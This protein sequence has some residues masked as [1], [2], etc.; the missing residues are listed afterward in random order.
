[1]QVTDLAVSYPGRPRVVDG[2][3]L[4][5][6]TGEIVGVSG[7]SGCGK[8][9]LALALIGLLPAH[10]NVSGS[11]RFAGRELREMHERDLESIRGAGIGLVFQESALALSPLLTVGT[12]ITE[13]V[14]AHE[15]C[16]HCA[17]TERARAV[18]SD[19]GLDVERSR[20]FN[21]YPHELSGGQRQRILIAQATACCPRLIVADEPVASLDE[22]T[23]GDVLALIR[24]L[25][26]RSGTS[27]LLITHS[28]E[29]LQT[30][31]TRVVEMND[32]RFMEASRPLRGA[33]VSLSTPRIVKAARPTATAE[34]IVEVSGLSKTYERRLLFGRRGPRVRALNGVDVTI[35]RGSTLG[36]AGR[37]GCG[38]STFARCLAGLEPPDAGQIR[39]NGT[40][41]AALEGRSLLPFRNQVQVIFQDSAAALNP[42]FSAFDIVAEP[43]VIQ[44]I[45][46]TADQRKRAA[47]LMEQVGLAADRLES[48]P[49]EFSGGERQR[50]AIARALAVNPRVL[51]L[52]ESFSGLDPTTRE[53][54]L[55]L[56]TEIQAAHGLTYVCIS[57]DRQLLAG[58]ATDV[59]V[60]HE[61]RIES[62]H[63]VIELEG[64]V[65]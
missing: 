6:E 20:I 35:A 25:N 42:R 14:R 39:I 33:A 11:I 48:R 43:L 36:V 40:N 18:M 38:K 22:G 58:F 15:R 3:S 44:G 52:D 54:I 46:T 57:H 16:S 55:R 26:E 62:R 41:I 30:T 8:T 65:A 2:A 27:F 28:A 49:H 29:V 59:V 9:T 32:G 1:L 34:T 64:A 7:P 50:I 61:G 31:A 60:L 47:G 63:G 56:L 17:A 53:R 4:S 45:G 12:Q 5:I 13:V 23:R 24:R 19:V 10:A 37:S 21:A 51:I